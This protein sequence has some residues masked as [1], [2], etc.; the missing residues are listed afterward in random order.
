MA[1]PGG[2]SPLPATCPAWVSIQPRGPGPNPPRPAAAPAAAR[3]FTPPSAASTAGVRRVRPLCRCAAGGGH[4]V[5]L[6]VR[7]RGPV[8]WPRSGRFRPYFCRPSGFCLCGSPLSLFQLR[9]AGLHQSF[10][11]HRRGHGEHL[12]RHTALT[13]GCP[14]KKHTLSLLSLSS[15]SRTFFSA[16]MGFASPKGFACRDA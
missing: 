16:S 11:T 13:V 8:D 15:I 5:I 1:T 2:P 7:V 3:A 14:A 4:A 12:R 10:Y 9:C 6:R